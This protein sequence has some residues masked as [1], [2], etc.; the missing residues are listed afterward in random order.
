VGGWLLYYSF[1]AVFV[2]ANQN[3]LFQLALEK[4]VNAEIMFHDLKSLRP[5]SMIN[6]PDLY[7]WFVDNILSFVIGRANHKK[8]MSQVVVSQFA[9]PSDISFAHLVLENSL[10]CWE[11]KVQARDGGGVTPKYSVTRLEQGKGDRRGWTKEGLE[12]FAVLFKEVQNTLQRDKG[13]FD[14]KYLDLKSAMV[15][16]GRKGHMDV[17]DDDDFEIPDS[18]SCCGATITML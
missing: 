15:L 8:V 6:Q 7:V 16:R 18:F 5:L 2:V 13:S 10:P 12:R 9:N 11:A 4:E 14:M 3:V 17:L 1:L